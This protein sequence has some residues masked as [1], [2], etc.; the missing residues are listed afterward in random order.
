MGS[1]CNKNH[2]YSVEE[3]AL[4]ACRYDLAL[5]HD[6]A[7]KGTSKSKQSLA[8]VVNHMNQSYDLRH[9]DAAEEILEE[10]GA[11]YDEELDFWSY[12]GQKLT[13]G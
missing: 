10:L 11:N 2:D 13:I 6:I 9:S 1:E 7:E 4:I 3:V 12:N 8:H 5:L